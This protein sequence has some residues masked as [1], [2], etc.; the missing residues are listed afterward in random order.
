MLFMSRRRLSGTAVFI[1]N[2]LSTVVLL[3]VSLYVLK[4][5]GVFR[6]QSEETLS[7]EICPASCLNDDLTAESTAVETTPTSYYSAVEAKP[8]AKPWDSKYYVRGTPGPN[9]RGE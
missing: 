4:K 6:Q 8:T 7:D 2:T 5:T 3:Y 1:L 9:F